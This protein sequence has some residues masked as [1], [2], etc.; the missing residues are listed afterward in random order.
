MFK[1]I[2]SASALRDMNEL[3]AFIARDKP[4]AAAKWVEDL[5]AKC[6]LLAS[7]PEMGAEVPTLGLGIRST[8]F[9]RYVIYY[10]VGS[11]NLV[12]ILRVIAGDRDVK[13]L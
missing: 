11:S 12:E 3:A 10:Q 4:V 1:L 6:R 7:T 13:N 2:Y 5:E 8:Y 9:G